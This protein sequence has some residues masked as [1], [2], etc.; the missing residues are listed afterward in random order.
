MK[1]FNLKT[2]WINR[3]GQIAIGHSALSI[4][5]FLFDRVLYPIILVKFGTL[6][7]MAILTAA[8]G[9]ICLTLILLYEW[10]KVDWLGIRVVEELKE[11]GAH[12]VSRLNNKKGK[13]WAIAK[14]MAYIPSR[15]FLLV[16]WALKKGN[17]VAFFVLS[18]FEDAFKTTAFLRKGEFNGLK[19][20]DWLIF[21]AS[22]LVS[23]IYWTLQWSILLVPIKYIWHFIFG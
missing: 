4:L 16:M 10:M 21:S 23:N 17:L 6:T 3:L 20:R 18:I 7:G 14:V 19:T 22:L 9:L 8:S 13:Y 12:W 5:D 15:I 11:N 1:L 2:S